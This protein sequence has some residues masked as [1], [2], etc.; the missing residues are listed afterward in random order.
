MIVGLCGV[1]FIVEMAINVVLI[2]VIATLIKVGK[3]SMKA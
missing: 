3:K 2:G 1:N